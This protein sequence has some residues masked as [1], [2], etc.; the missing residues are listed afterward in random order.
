MC[1]CTNIFPP[2]QAA[3][4][5]NCPVCLHEPVQKQDCRPNKAL[6]TTTK[7][8]LKRKLIERDAAAKKK[9][10]ALLELQTPTT[11]VITEA[12]KGLEAGL[13]VSKNVDGNGD[14]DQQ[15]PKPSVGE[16]RAQGS[17]DAA[18]NE[19]TK[20]IPKLSIEVS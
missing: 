7:A 16:S 3:L 12:E 9:A 15:K 11:P 10:K 2:G 13:T 19:A 18:I 4:D 17:P 8:F 6:R 20:D 14:E 5:T 1:V